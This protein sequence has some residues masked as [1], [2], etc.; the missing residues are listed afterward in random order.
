[1]DVF[2]QRQF[3]LDRSML[4]KWDV[5]KLFQSLGCQVSGNFGNACNS[6]KTFPV[7]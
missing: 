4:W 3:E 2:G 5:S 7:L 1:M 6:L